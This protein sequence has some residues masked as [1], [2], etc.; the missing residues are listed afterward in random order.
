ML[1]G[2]PHAPQAPAEWSVYIARCADDS[3]YTGTAKDVAKRLD[4]HNSGHGAAYTRSH[5]PVRLVYQED[6]LTRS[7]ALVREARIKSQSRQTKELLIDGKLILPAK[8]RTISK[9]MIP[10]LFFLFSLAAPARAVPTFVKEDG[11]R[12]ASVTLTGS[13]SVN[14]AGARFY[15]VRG[16]TAV[17]SALT[18]DGGMSFTEDA[19]VRLSTYTTPR[20]DVSSITAV[21][22][23]QLTNNTYRMLY[24]AVGST[25]TVFRIY[26]ASSTDG[27]TWYND[28][29]TR[30]D[31]NGGV[32]Y[33]GSPSLIKRSNGDW[34]LYYVAN[35]DGGTAQSSRRV[36]SALSTNQGR[37][38]AAGT[39][40]ANLNGQVGDTA[41]MART[42]NTVRLYYTAPLANSTTY[43]TILSAL[44]TS[45]DNNG[46][47]FSQESGTRLSTDAATGLLSA[48]FLVRSTET[49]RWKL[50]YNWTPFPLS[51]TP[52]SVYCATVFAPD[53]T[54]LTPNNVLRTAGTQTF[55]VAG[56]AFSGGGSGSAPTFTL[57]QTGGSLTGTSIVRTDDQN[58]S[59]DFTLA[60]NQGLGYWNLTAVNDNGQ[61]TVLNNAV[62][63]DFAPGTVKLT[64]NLI[65]PRLG[66]RTRIDVMTNNSGGM[67]LKLYTITGRPVATIYDTSNAAQ[68]TTT[69]YWDGK[70]AQGGTVAS[71]VYILRTRGQKVDATDK[72]VVIK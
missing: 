37:D 23:M 68:G 36:F 9:S 35:A 8:K 70:T 24:S 25:G 62:Y 15:Y 65:R 34:R 43:S 57:D 26:S 3:L 52:P 71:G 56:E 13:S 1:E 54:S 38:F 11:V 72:I 41:A 7:Q 47:I 31:N 42:D 20:L 50:Y 14:M 5:G 29:G 22:V 59:V 55:K 49:W 40:L 28:T 51:A 61:T 33:I 21:S 44:T 45:S 69:V 4:Q 12:I 63:I 2:L 30:V 67:T 46:T 32:G 6:G 53:P 64:D 17:Y 18:A 66:A 39:Q 27:L 16:S 10:L 58:I 19:G 48:P 60:S